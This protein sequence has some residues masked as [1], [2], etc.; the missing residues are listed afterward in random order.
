[1]HFSKSLLFAAAATNV[2][3]LATHR[4]RHADF[5]KEKRAVGDVVTAVIDGKEVTWVNE[6][7]GSAADETDE[8]TNELRSAPIGVYKST[9]P[10]SSVVSV[11]AAKATTTSAAAAAASSS[12]SSG[13]SSSSSL[14]TYQPFC[15]KSTKRAT[16]AEIAYKGNTGINWGCNFQLVDSSIISSYKYLIKV[17]G[18]NTVPW[19]F[20]CWNKIGPT[21][22]IDGWYNHKAVEFT[23]APGGVQYIALD[24]NS[25]GSCSAA[26]G[27]NLPKDSWGGWGGTWFEFDFEN[28]SN[29]GWSGADV[30]SI[31]AE[32]G[33]LKVYGMQ[34]KWNGVVS[35]IGEDLSV[36]DNAF[37]EA[38]KYAD[39]IGMN[40]PAGAA[41]VDVIIDW[42]K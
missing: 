34:A 12:S 16:E 37:D 6:Y 18:Q 17:T 8:E 42:H 36:V 14:K 20:W 33:K 32:A 28:A 2:A 25:Q 22:L 11:A 38:L 23:L 39:G 15:S 9:P 10:K 30:S 19:T 41:T 4:H 24:S 40:I 7:D 31:Q 35:T 29:K 13:S 1:M 27:T 3:G 21:G 26:P 5:H